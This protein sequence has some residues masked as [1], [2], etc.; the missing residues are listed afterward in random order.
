MSNFAAGAVST[1][2]T[3]NKTLAL[4]FPFFSRTRFFPGS[5]TGWLAGGS[6]QELAEN[7][8]LTI[9]TEGSGV[10]TKVGPMYQSAAGAAFT[11]DGWQVGISAPPRAFVSVGISVSAGDDWSAAHFVNVP[12]LFALTSDIF[13]DSTQV[14]S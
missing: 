9:F 3:A 13:P 2:A 7:I 5:C 1:L 11:S 6:N 12:A 10:D 8:R 14:D 4:R